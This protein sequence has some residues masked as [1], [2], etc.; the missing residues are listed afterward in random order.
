MKVRMICVVVAAMAVG[1]GGAVAAGETA[2]AAP[3]TVISTQARVEISAEGKVIAVQPDP[4]LPAAVGEAIRKTIAGWRFAAPLKDGHPVGGVTYVRLGACAAELH[5]GLKM[6]FNYQGN[7]PRRDGPPTPQPPFSIG[8]MRPGQSAKMQLTYRVGADGVAA[9]ESMDRIEGKANI[10]RALRSSLQ[11]WIA[12]ST[13]S[14]ELVAGEPV[15]TRM[16]MPIEFT[17][18]KLD[19]AQTRRG[20][21]AVE[22]ALAADRPTCQA[23]LGNARK[24]DKV[25]ALDSPFTLLPSG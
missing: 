12:A 11:D 2:G 18:L 9:V 8:K 1:V 4:K 10:S 7:G 20:P 5:D 14:P 24:Q 22:Q 15:A 21:K 23:V 3:L 13:F 6:A 17:L 25:V 19:R 16:S